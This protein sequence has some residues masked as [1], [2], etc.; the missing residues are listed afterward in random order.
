[1]RV[2]I[3][4]IC[5]CVKLDNGVIPKARF[6]IY[7]IRFFNK[8]KYFDM[9]KVIFTYL[10]FIMMSSILAYIKNVFLSQNRQM[11]SLTLG[12]G[13]YIGLW[14]EWRLLVDVLVNIDYLMSLILLQ[15]DNNQGEMPTSM[16]D[17][18]IPTACS[19]FF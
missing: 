6:T 3:K 1:M 9:S 4:K 16:L 2:L 8:I 15:K 17:K 11:G 19:I 5:F 7:L 12:E 14:G 13:R 10:I 18:W